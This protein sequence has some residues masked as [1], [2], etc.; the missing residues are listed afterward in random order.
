MTGDAADATVVVADPTGPA[1]RPTAPP[2][3]PAQ[4]LTAAYCAERAAAAIHTAE[5]A[6]LGPQESWLLCA[7]R[8]H[9]L[10]V[11]MA[12]NLITRPRDPDD[13]R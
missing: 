5:T 10:A 4:P 11:A 13:A 12:T 2:V 1:A 6:P 7:E 3:G 8:W 9:A